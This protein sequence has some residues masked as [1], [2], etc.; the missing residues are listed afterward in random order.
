MTYPRV[1]CALALFVLLVFTPALATAQEPAHTLQDLQSDLYANDKVRLMHIDGTSVQGK[2]DSVSA[3]VLKIRVKGIVRE[4]PSQQ[5]LTVR[6]QYND[7][8]RNGLAIGAAIGGSAGAVIGAIVSDAFCD[9][10]GTAQASGALVFG[11]L[12]AGIGAGSGAL[13]DS[14][15]KGYKTVFTMPRRAELRF[16]LS[17]VLSKKTKGVA[18]A[19]RF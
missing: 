19:F 2:V 4:F 7:P 18:V 16:N 3:T 8:I 11:L 6:K 9:G 12:G 14:L 1:P 15:R 5:I 17:P 10:C 13:G